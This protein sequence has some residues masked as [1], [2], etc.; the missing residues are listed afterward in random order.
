MSIQKMISEHPDVDGHLNDPLAETVKHAMYAAAIMNSCADACGAEE[1][2]MRQCIRACS[3]A[4]DAA[5]ALSR[6]AARRTGSNEGVIR[7][8]LAFARTAAE[9]CKAECDKMDNAHC[10]RCSTMCQELIDDIANA[11]L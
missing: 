2:D 1:G 7:A 9:A 5:Q 10:R 8:A 11:N 6:V 3:D 4:S